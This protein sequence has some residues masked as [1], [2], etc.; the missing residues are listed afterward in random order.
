MANN[1]GTWPTSLQGLEHAKIFLSPPQCFISI[2]NARARPL[3]PV[4]IGH[5]R[6]CE[7]EC[8][9]QNISIFRSSGDL[10]PYKLISVGTYTDIYI[11]WQFFYSLKWWIITREGNQNRY[12]G[13]NDLLSSV[14]TH[15]HWNGNHHC[16]FG[17]NRLDSNIQT[18]S[19][20]DTNW[21]GILISHVYSSMAPLLR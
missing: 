2:S 8:I 21:S 12:A 4:K 3:H 13:G 14:N 16:N 10:R 20:S 15:Q 6:I 18:R 7:Q 5:Y 9:V 19:A 1:A 17:M 11:L